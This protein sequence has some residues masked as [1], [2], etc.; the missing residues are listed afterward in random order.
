MTGTAAVENRLESEEHLSVIG[1]LVL[2]SI[3]AHLANRRRRRG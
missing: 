3:L 1:G 2:A